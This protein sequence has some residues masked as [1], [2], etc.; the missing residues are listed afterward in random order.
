MK[1][2]YKIRL[3]IQGKIKLLFFFDKDGGGWEG[4]GVSD[5]FLTNW[6]RIQ[7]CDLFCFFFLAGCVGG[8]F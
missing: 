5:I 7:I 1:S 8:F 3:E 2:F 4:V 6:Q